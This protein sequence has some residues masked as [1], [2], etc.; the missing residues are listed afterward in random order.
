M[1]TDVLLAPDKFKGSL[2]ASE[3]ADA[4]R[5]GLTEAAPGARVIAVPIA[6]GGD[7]TLD[8]AISAGDRPVP[9]RV[10]GPTGEPVDT[11]YAV[12]DWV[13]VVE[14]ADACGL[15]RLAAGQLAPLTATSTGFGEVIAAALDSGCR[16]V[17]LGVGGSASTDGGAGMLTSL[18]MRIC[19]A[20]GLDVPPGGGALKLVDHLDVS[21][22]A[23]GGAGRRIRPGQ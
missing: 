18:G 19:G 23:S 7:G 8:A 16:R 4:L 10:T 3:V 1:T 21:G 20:D 15:N 12:R 14:L 6:D 2:R 5:I 22:S 11:A 13:G 17:I 9:V